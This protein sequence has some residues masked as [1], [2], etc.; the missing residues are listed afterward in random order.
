MSTHGN[1]V[2]SITAAEHI[3][4]NDTGD[5]IE[6]K[7]VANYGFDGANWQRTPTPLINVA[8]DQVSFSNPDGS[9]N[10]QTGTVKR[11]GITV[12]TLT[13]AYDGNN[14]VTDYSFSPA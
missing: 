14:N 2:P 8:Y 1:V 4:P 11:S 13:L 5:N 9:G 12:G 7:R 3:G 6:A 10:Y